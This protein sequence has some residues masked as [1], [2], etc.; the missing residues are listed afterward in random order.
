MDHRRQSPRLVAAVLAGDTLLTI[1]MNCYLNWV[2]SPDFVGFGRPV[3]L[4]V[5]SRLYTNAFFLAVSL[6][7][8]WRAGA[9]SGKHWRRQQRAPSWLA[10]MGLDI[11]APRELLAETGSYGI[12][13]SLWDL[14]R[15]YG[16]LLGLMSAA[17]AVATGIDA[18]V[19]TMIPLP[20]KQVVEATAPVVGVLLR[21]GWLAVAGLWA[22]ARTAWASDFE[23]LNGSPAAPM[24]RRRCACCLGCCRPS[25]PGALRLASL[26]GIVVGTALT[27][28]HASSGS[29]RGVLLDFATVVI[30]SGMMMITDWLLDGKGFTPL[31]LILLMAPGSALTMW[32]FAWRNSGWAA[33]ISDWPT[34]RT[35]LWYGAPL[36][37]LL[38]LTDLG[39]MWLVD[40]TSAITMLVS[41]NVVVVGMLF[42]DAVVFG[43]HA[44][45]EVLNGA[46][47][48]LV[49]LSLVG[50]TAAAA[51][52]RS[53]REAE[54]D[55]AGP[56]SR[57]EQDAAGFSLIVRADGSSDEQ[58]LVGAE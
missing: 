54:Y 22:Y 34:F 7:A 55:D 20:L 19:Y 23:P 12:R 41:S 6:V 42:A 8:M 30:V 14:T 57:T 4:A 18:M 13:H 37:A 32:G 40:R 45:I 33:R 51:A 3:L 31:S 39:N 49:V 2:L 11:Y 28:W 46:G 48:G 9:F 52:A 26:V 1:V 53:A 21:G 5:A 24:R 38:I 56:V 16:L 35:A 27:V 50:Y 17:G 47:I 44:R 15:R 29:V 10:F 58:T 43:H 25:W 36:G